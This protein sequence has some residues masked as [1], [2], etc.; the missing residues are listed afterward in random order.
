[1]TDFLDICRTFGQL[2]DISL[3]DVKFPDISSFSQYTTHSTACRYKSS[4]AAEMCD[5]LATINMGRKVGGAA[6]P[7]PWRELGPIYH[8]VT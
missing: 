8:N 3:T 6:V 4:A 2:P 1:M 7:F 5:H